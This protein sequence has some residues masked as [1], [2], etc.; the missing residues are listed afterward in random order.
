M[1]N[2]FL[3]VQ[4]ETLRIAG[5]TTVNLVE[6]LLAMV[7]NLTAELTHLR[8]FNAV[9]QVQ[10]CELQNLLSTKSCHME[11]AAGTSSSQPGIMSFKDAQVI[12]Q[13]QQVRNVNTSK[14]SRNLVSTNQKSKTA[15]A[16]AE[17]PA[18]KKSG[19]C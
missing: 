2:E 16:V 10:I 7:T 18:A 19:L 8:S 9:L 13:H 4:I 1:S 3:N 5:Q 12:S 17:V 15:N 6:K 11:A 14:N